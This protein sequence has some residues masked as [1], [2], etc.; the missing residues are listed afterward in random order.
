LDVTKQPSSSPP[1]P[2]PSPSSPRT[3]AQWRAY[4]DGLEGDALVDAASAANGIGFVEVL[5]GEG[6]APDQIHAV[7]YAFAARF[8]A[9]GRRP[10]GGGLYDFAALARRAAPVVDDEPGAPTWSDGGGAKV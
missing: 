6:Y 2:S 1:S 9:L 3:L 10:P 5:E 4:I 7:L 8:V